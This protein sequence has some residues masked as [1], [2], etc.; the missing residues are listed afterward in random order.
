MLE[1]GD[2]ST[3]LDAPKLTSSFDLETIFVVPSINLSEARPEGVLILVAEGSLTTRM[4]AAAAVSQG[5]VL[6]FMGGR[7]TPS[8]ASLDLAHSW[9]KG[10]ERALAV[11]LGDLSHL[12][13]VRTWLSLI[14]AQAA[15]LLGIGLGPLAL[16]VCRSVLSSVLDSEFHSLEDVARRAV[17]VRRASRFKVTIR[18]AA[19]KRADIAASC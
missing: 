4:K 14:N 16:L 6:L 2:I 19:I 17:R 13:I 12:A 8:Q 1:S 15:L 3:F 18:R 9:S 5:D 7:S 11:L 10:A